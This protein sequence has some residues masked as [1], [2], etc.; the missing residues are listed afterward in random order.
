MV[1]ILQVLQEYVLAKTDIAIKLNPWIISYFGESMYHIL[2][3]RMIGGHSISDQTKWDGQFIID[4]NGTGWQE[5]KENLL[6]WK[7]L[8]P[9]LLSLDIEQN[10]NTE[11]LYVVNVSKIGIQPF[12]P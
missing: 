4:V 10:Y 5:L 3:I 7:K 8:F 12:Y 9:N 11:Y 6:L 2:H 1:S